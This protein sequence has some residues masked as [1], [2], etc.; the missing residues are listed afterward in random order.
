MITI[1]MEFVKTRRRP[2]LTARAKKASG[3][4]G[5]P[6]HTT[7]QVST[8]LDG[9]HMPQTLTDVSLSKAGK[10]SCGS[11][12]THHVQKL[13]RAEVNFD[14]TFNLL[15][16]PSTKSVAAL[17]VRCFQQK[18]AVPVLSHGLRHLEH[19]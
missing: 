17:F 2:A 6:I 13:A 8:K 5:M 10:N 16:R 4:W 12:S 7:S 1:F 3:S 19:D 18:S 9:V 14:E 11:G 15:T